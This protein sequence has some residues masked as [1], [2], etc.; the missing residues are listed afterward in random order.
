MNISK[1][2]YLVVLLAV[3]AILFCSNAHA[4]WSKL[5][6]AP[7][8]DLKGVWTNAPDNVW[9]VGSSGTVIHLRQLWL[10]RCERCDNQL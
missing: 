2:R 7:L 4:G 6:L 1:R 3:L 10:A 5:N 9:I 8:N